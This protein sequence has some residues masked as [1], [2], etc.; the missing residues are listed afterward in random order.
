MKIYRKQSF[1]LIEVIIAVAIF[2]LIL[3]SVYV[4]LQVG[5]KSW[6]TYSSTV[7]LKQEVR[8]AL[9]AMSGE[10]R[11]AKN[12]FI[13]KDDHNHSIS[14]NFERPSVGIVS[15]SWSDSGENAYKIIRENYTELR[16]LASNITYLS[17]DYPLDNEIII[18]VTAGK[19]ITFNLKEKIALRLKTS[20]FIH[21]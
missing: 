21:G 20:L 12:I 13:T 19:E 1:T 5:Q 9:I 10:L 2:T 4:T 8:R 16:T 18:N 11:E 14:I 15:Y 6:N 17:F 3:E 7:L